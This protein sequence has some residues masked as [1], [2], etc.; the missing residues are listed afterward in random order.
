MVKET[1]NSEN[2]TWYVSGSVEGHRLKIDLEHS[3]P[4]TL[5]PE[6]REAI[7]KLG[8][9]LSYGEF[10]KKWGTHFASTIVYGGKAY[11]NLTLQKDFIKRH[12]MTQKDF[13]LSIEG[14]FKKVSG[15]ASGSYGE[16]TAGTTTEEKLFKQVKAVAYGGDGSVIE[17]DVGAFNDWAKTVRDNPTVLRLSL[18][19]YHKLLNKD[20]FPND[21]R[22]SEKQVKLKK[23]IT[24]YLKK[25]KVDAPESGDFFKDATKM[26]A[27]K[28][29]YNGNYLALCRNC[30]GVIN[31]D[32]P[33]VHIDEQVVKAAS[34]AHWALRKLDNK[35]YVLKSSYNGNYLSACHDCKIHIPLKNK[36]GTMATFYKSSRSDSALVRITER[37]VERDKHAQWDLIELANGKYGL[38]STWNKKYLAVCHNCG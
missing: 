38:K 28:S 35:T 25:H 32:S 7:Q 11:F 20:F 18:T 8:Q 5:T 37:E 9:T 26:I 1:T 27:L 31:V 16:T 4:L 21:P 22:I 36:N 29:V 2:R 10:I 34:E 3:Q 17:G 33:Y 19:E 23:V 6:F 13:D 24:A 30:R 14:T 12:K 15:A